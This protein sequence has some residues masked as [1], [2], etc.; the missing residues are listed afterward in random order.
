[1][2]NLTT[3]MACNRPF[4]GLWGDECERRLRQ[5]LERVCEVYGDGTVIVARSF[6]TFCNS[7]EYAVAKLVFEYAI[8]GLGQCWRQR[9]DQSDFHQRQ[10]KRVA[11]RLGPP[12]L[13]VRH[14]FTLPTVPSRSL[15]SEY[16]RAMLRQAVIAATF[17]WRN[18]R[19]APMLQ[20]DRDWRLIRTM[21]PELRGAYDAVDEFRWPDWRLLPLATAAMLLRR[22]AR[23]PPEI[24]AMILDLSALNI[25]DWFY[26]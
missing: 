14:S 23:L 12:G 18:Y 5:T 22:R 6:I 21:N 3:E 20:H 25:P 4:C 13:R 17:G 10:Y 26:T 15:R 19:G 16:T 1:M 24:I 9:F 2:H 8:D 7:D 11:R